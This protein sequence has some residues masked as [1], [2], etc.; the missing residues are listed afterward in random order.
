LPR[1]ETI[2]IVE[3]VRWADDA[4]LDAI[5]YLSRRIPGVPAILFLTF[6]EEDVDATHPLRRILG[7]L[8]GSLHRRLAHRDDR[9]GTAGGVEGVRVGHGCGAYRDAGG[10]VRVPATGGA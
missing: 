6:R 3:D 9:G 10:V 2:V 7:G 8:H 4:T 5:R 1:P